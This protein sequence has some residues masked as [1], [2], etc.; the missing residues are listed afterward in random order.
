M[1]SEYYVLRGWSEEG[2]P[3]AAKLKE[4]GLEECLM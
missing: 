4:L 3:T 1:L 2:M